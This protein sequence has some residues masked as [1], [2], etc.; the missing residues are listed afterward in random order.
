MTAIPRPA[1]DR[2]GADAVSGGRDQGRVIRPPSS[3]IL[4]FY[5]AAGG[6]MTAGS[7]CRHEFVS[8]EGLR[9]VS[10]QSSGA[11]RL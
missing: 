10:G 8:T 4:A 2:G 3:A 7:S 9:P 11:I 1:H 6:A 5:W